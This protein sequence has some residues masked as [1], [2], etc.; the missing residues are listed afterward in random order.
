MTAATELRHF[1]FQDSLMN[2]PT[3]SMVSPR[4]FTAYGEA[5][6]PVN[7]FI[8]GRDKS[9]Q[10]DLDV[11]R[12]FFQNMTFPPDFYRRDGAIS[13]EGYETVFNAYPIVPGANQGKVNSYKYDPSSAILSEP[14]KR[15][16]TFVENNIKSLYP[17]PTG[18]L[19]QALNINLQYLFDAT[20]AAGD[21]CTQVFPYG[22]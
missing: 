2:N 18:V 22:Q 11:A 6:F 16:T 19:R 8:D 13:N 15:Y 14:C 9:G 4:L 20:V 7:F 1:L 5:V 10:L 12:G 21:N 3:F 17:N